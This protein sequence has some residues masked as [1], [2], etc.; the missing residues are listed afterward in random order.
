M[1][2]Y[3][4]GE[5]VDQFSRVISSEQEADIVVHGIDARDFI[6]DFIIHDMT[7]KNTL[8]DAGLDFT[9]TPSQERLPRVCSLA[10]S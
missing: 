9:V 5:G 6:I 1:S 7:E 10:I 3:C 4:D 2:D 8:Y